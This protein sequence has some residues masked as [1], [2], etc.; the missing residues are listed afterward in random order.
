MNETFSNGLEVPGDPNGES[1]EIINCRC[2]VGYIS[3]EDSEYGQWGR[4]L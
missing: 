3:K 2:T 4:N 1:E